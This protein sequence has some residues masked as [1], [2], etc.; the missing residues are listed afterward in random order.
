MITGSDKLDINFVDGE[1]SI[2][3][4]QFK[5]KA[6]QTNIRPNNINNKYNTIQRKRTRGD[7]WIMLWP[8]NGA[9][10]WKM[11]ETIIGFAHY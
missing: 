7:E 3:H 6:H 9:S 1:Y 4:S 2:Y 5:R 10:R 8:N 11:L